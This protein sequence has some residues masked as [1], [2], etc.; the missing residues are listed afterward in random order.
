MRLPP[1]AAL[2]GLVLLACGL[3][4]CAS[5][6]RTENQA[7]LAMEDAER[8]RAQG[9]L[10]PGPYA[11]F[12]VRDDRPESAPRDTRGL[13]D[14]PITRIYSQDRE[15]V[16]PATE[17]LERELRESTPAD[18]GAL[19]E[20]TL[21]IGEF[22]YVERDLDAELIQQEVRARFGFAS[23]AAEAATGCSA[24]YRFLF[25]SWRIRGIAGQEPSFIQSQAQA[26]LLAQIRRSYSAW[27]GSD[28]AVPAILQV[29]EPGSDWSPDQARI[30]RYGRLRAVQGI[31]GTPLALVSPNGLTA[32]DYEPQA[33]QQRGSVQLAI[34]QMVGQLLLPDLD[35]GNGERFSRQ[36][37]PRVELEP[38][39]LGIAG[40]DIAIVRMRV[41]AYGDDAQKA[42]YDRIL[43]GECEPGPLT[44]CT[45]YEQL[46]SIARVLRAELPA[47]ARF[48]TRS[49]NA[50][51][52]TPAPKDDRPAQ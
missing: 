15:F 9:R 35:L 31:V 21:C 36:R 12:V 52:Q 27:A 46:E 24:N 51:A 45:V 11:N 19:P 2:A 30:D 17:L 25:A 13:R 29:I 40:D 50:P 16:F 10:W 43:E 3:A 18:P 41:K 42:V 47:V 32:T 22:S 38:L 6:P 5:L 37:V 39:Y 49:S 48:I 4:G 26:A 14:W 1:H 8:A 33:L 34:G 7:Y 44:S 28:D 23:E 20:V